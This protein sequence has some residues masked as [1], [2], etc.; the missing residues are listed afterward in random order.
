MKHELGWTDYQV[1]AEQAIVRHWQ[2]VL[3]AYTFSLLAGASAGTVLSRPPPPLADSGPAPARSPSATPALDQVAGGGKIRTA[4][5]QPARRAG[6]LGG[7]AP[8]GA[9][10]AL[11]LGTAAALL[12]AL[13]QQRPA[14]RAG[15]APRPSRQRSPT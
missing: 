15:R 9:Q 1:R 13:V 11:S 10:L 4:T 14:A 6:D 2:L 12:D 3:L 7:D 8:V 5:R